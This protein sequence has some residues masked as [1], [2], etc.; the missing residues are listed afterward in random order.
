ML[1][2]SLFWSDV[3][4]FSG[5]SFMSNLARCSV[6]AEVDRS[7]GLGSLLVQMSYIDILYVYASCNALLVHII[8]ADNRPALLLY[9]LL[10]VCGVVLETEQPRCP[11]CNVTCV[12]FP[13]VNIL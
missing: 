11:Q 9:V 5:A 1:G 2:L 12:P 7:R 10:C 6:I 8:S 4:S 3:D 13:R